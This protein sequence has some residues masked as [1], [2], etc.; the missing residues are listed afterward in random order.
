MLSGTSS[1]SQNSMS[2][3]QEGTHTPPFHDADKLSAPLGT[4]FFGDGSGYGLEGRGGSSSGSARELE[5]AAVE[6]DSQEDF[7]LV[8]EVS[9][10]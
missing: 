8:H 3:T 5:R 2:H 1:A 6:Y 7:A 10:R 4:S 9:L